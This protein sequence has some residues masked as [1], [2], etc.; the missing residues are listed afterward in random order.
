SASARE[1]S[2]AR[3]AAEERLQLEQRQFDHLAS[4]VGQLFDIDEPALAD[5]L[6]TR[7]PDEQTRIRQALARIRDSHGIEGLRQ[8]LTFAELEKRCDLWQLHVE[9]DGICHIRS[10]DLETRLRTDSA[11]RF[12][13]ELHKFYRTLPESKSL[14]MVLLSW[15]DASRLSWDN[16]ERVMDQTLNRLRIEE[17]RRI[18]FESAVLGYLP[19]LASAPPGAALR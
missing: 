12:A 13:A 5:L 7:S 2:L 1:Q 15:D 3:V 19:R 11:D 10:G 17:D 6:T 14:V 4:L 18:R 8:I 16:A 9:D